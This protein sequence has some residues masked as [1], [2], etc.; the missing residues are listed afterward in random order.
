MQALPLVYSANVPGY[1]DAIEL[2]DRAIAL[3]PGYAPA[4]ALASWAHE[5]RKTLA[6]TAPA[7]VDDVEISLALA[8]RALDADPNDAMAMGLLGWQ[9]ICSV[10]TTQG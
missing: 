6:G 7:G 5:K 2:L 1:T 4:L 8:Q 10:A 9:R 3:A